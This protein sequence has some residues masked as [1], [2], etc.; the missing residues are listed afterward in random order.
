MAEMSDDHRL[1]FGLLGAF[2]VDRDGR[3]VYLG[4]RLQR[5]LLAI[6]VVDAGHVV[7]VDRLIDLLWRDEPPAAAIASVQAYVSQLRRVL[8]PDRPARAPAR[9][10]VTQDP[11]YVLRIADDQVDALR[12][13]ALVRRAH[14]NL[15]GGQP[16]AAATRL[17]DAFALWHGD[18]LAEFA[19]EPWAVPAVAR[20]TEAH[21]LAT[22]DRIGAW[23]ALGRHAEAVAE[24]EAMVEA[25]P[26]RERRWGQ[27]IVAT[28]RCG[29][30]ADALRAYQRCR[31][32]LAGELGLEPGPEL[33]RLEAAVLAQDPSLD[34]QP[35]AGPAGS[36][37]PGP[38]PPR[39]QPGRAE[40]P[41][42][43][44]PAAEPP[45]EGDHP[46]PS[47]VGRDA[48]LAHLRDRLADA[49]SGHGGA[50]VLVGEPGAGK[51]TI[52]EAAAHMAGGAGFT[53]AW[54]RC[55]DAAST[56]AYWP[57]S[58]VLRAL[59]D[60]PSVAAARQRL[61][62]DVEGEG[63]D[64]VRQ[65][66]AYKAVA[67]ALGEAAASTP[68]LAV[69][70]DLHAADEASLALLQLLAGDL[71][72]MPALLL[73]TV[74]DTEPVPSV[75]Q[76]LGE[77]LRHPGAERVAV[78]AL[79]A[80]DVATLLERL[81]V[82]PPD[83]DVVSAVMDRTGG[84]PF[85]TTEL[86]RLVSSEH[87]SR[88]LTAGDVL[89]LDV[90]SGI[91]D[92]LLRRVHRLPDDTQSLLMV[93][94]V[95]GR[96]LQ[97]ELLEQV[98]GLD[99]E[100]LLLNLEPAIAAGLVTEAEAGWGFR[101]RHPLIHESL[102]ASAGQV[103]RA[104]LHARIAA[105]LEDASPAST[106]AGL[107]QLAYH[108][109]SAGPFGDP[110]KAVKYAREAAGWAVRQGAWHDAVRHLEQALT[111]ISPARPDADATRCDVLVE[112]GRA[113]RSGSMIA[114]AHAALEE[115]I[116]L[117]DRIGDED[118][119][120]AAAVA[121]GAP[122]L[123]GSREWGETDT[124][125]IALLERQLDRIADTDPARRVRILSTL[126]GELAFGEMVG[127]SWGYAEEAL[128]IARRLGQPDELG[129][130]IGGYLL[131]A[132][133]TD[134]LPE[135]RAVIDEM[136]S[137][138]RLAFTP[139][140]QALLRASQLT[141]LIRSG[142]LARFDAEFP[143][144][145]AL[146]AG[147][148][149][150]P[151]LQA[152]LRFAQ[153][154]RYIVAGD[155]ERGAEIAEHTFRTMADVTGPW[156]QPAGFVNESSQLLVTGRLAD[157]A[158]QLAA[159][160]TRPDHPSVPHLAAPAAALG[161]VLRGDLRA[162]REIV[163]GWFAPPPRSW[164]WIQAVAYWAQV[165]I[166][167]GEPD[168]GWLHEQLAPHA[169]E[170]AVVGVGADCGGAVDSLLA[171]L[172]WR[173]GR[174][175]EAAGRA[176]AGLT[177]ETRVGSGIWITRTEG[178]IDRISAETPARRADDGPDHR[179]TRGLSAAWQGGRRVSPRPAGR[180][181]PALPVIP[182]HDVV[183]GAAV[184]P[185]ERPQRP[186]GRVAQA[187]QVDGE[188]AAGEPQ[189]PLRLLLVGNRRVAG[190][191]AE[192]GR[193][194]HHVRGGLAEVIQHEAALPLV[195]R[196]PG[197]QG[198]RRRRLGDVPAAP[199]PDLGQLGQ[200]RAVGDHHKVPRLPVSRRWRPPSRLADA[201][202]VLPGDRPVGVLAHVAAR[203]DSIPRLHVHSP[204][205]R[206]PGGAPPRPL[207][208]LPG[209]HVNLATC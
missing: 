48:E 158:E 208:T 8:E 172:A 55:P 52:A 184:G 162:A 128:G 57:W 139:V 9:V 76:A 105:A 45:R 4:P 196:L 197:H 78:S 82:R 41:P 87:R 62:G 1:H 60:G 11:G 156:R 121:F 204:I 81:T 42:A 200:L 142:E 123:W 27:L 22:E 157:Q 187:D 92:V 113:C 12:F 181:T 2:R 194:Q 201:L 77:L 151:E 53:S 86:V 165:A 169:G 180:P 160:I 193:G 188:V 177:L 103:E 116:S 149:H 85:Y 66:R 191:D 175:G 144:T 79:E 43:F 140:V 17:E 178:L 33:R 68:V 170:L 102:R 115:S 164:T 32:V 35:A 99:T 96:E 31:T 18:P 190:A 40:R 120:L 61:D 30:Q 168:P 145:W 93:A 153:A 131:A 72:R 207:C 206:P 203:P 39:V 199:F 26:L 71:H 56:P 21:D 155:V 176:R 189:H 101:F 110:A 109:L 167:L 34:W 24:L 90:P 29:R 141:E 135:R 127:R 143:P 51:T 95:A 58:Q 161:F 133:G 146:A 117:A 173:L 47:L 98:T 36:G 69:V 125:L 63:D 28:Y 50:V 104:R 59:P 23:L 73:F 179:S 129:I 16:A 186:V 67:A 111:A 195:L 80:A 126:A 49:A 38:V 119:V 100:Q 185:D 122:A 84:N 20:L 182:V 130:A 70:D 83:A 134:H 19:D 154:C 6:L 132:L 46:A 37:P 163:S 64:G 166:A 136:L 108:Y 192:V 54:G 15:A 205:A 89:T 10:L 112:L 159:R 148:L 147:V 124:R 94:A 107:A 91:R 25:R 118:R 65:F 7:P 209:L 137:S 14:N 88:R 106:A 114:E 183:E 198:D 174:P 3:E 152:Q 75:G 44:P 74:R 5:T 138:D 202:K 150:S 171:G 97:P 13:Q